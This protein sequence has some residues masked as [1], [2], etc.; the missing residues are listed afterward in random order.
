MGSLIVPIVKVPPFLT[1]SNLTG[2]KRQNLFAGIFTRGLFNP[3]T[4]ECLSHFSK[5]C[6]KVSGM[7]KSL[8]SNGP[9]PSQGWLVTYT[10]PA[11]NAIVQSG[12]AKHSA[13]IERPHSVS[14]QFSQ[15]SCSPTPVEAFRGQQFLEIVQ[16]LTQCVVRFVF[17]KGT[18]HLRREKI[19]INFKFLED[20]R[21]EQRHRRASFPLIWAE[22]AEFRH[23]L[24]NREKTSDWM[25]VEA[26]S[27]E[28]FSG[29]RFPGNRE[30]NR[31]F[32][33]S[34]QPDSVD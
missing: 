17:R 30:K 19:A 13:S 22:F 6:A 32:R 15:G 23:N 14:V 34:L 11:L 20:E 18:S 7:M 10:R 3:C 26:G 4:V 2:S 27:C 31:E 24:G 29:S 16:Q 5:N 28:P 33:E 9:I 12:I 25:A 21:G 8:E 1:E